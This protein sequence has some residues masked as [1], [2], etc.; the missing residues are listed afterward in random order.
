MNKFLSKKIESFI[1]LNQNL[2]NGNDFNEI[3]IRFSEIDNS[4]RNLSKENFLKIYNFYK[5]Q[6]KQENE[7]I[8]DY[9][10]KKNIILFIF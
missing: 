4:Q 10:F 7:I 5:T 2:N 1:P 3:E 6:K 8:V 9:I